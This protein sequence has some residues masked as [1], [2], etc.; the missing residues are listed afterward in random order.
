[1]QAAEV[2]HP[3]GF[4]RRLENDSG[5]VLWKIRGGSIVWD[6]QVAIC[7]AGVSTLRG[8]PPFSK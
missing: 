3:S 7:A 6:L 1:M 2:F 5:P 8:A 4:R